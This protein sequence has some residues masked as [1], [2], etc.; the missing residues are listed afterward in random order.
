MQLHLA[1]LRALRGTAHGYRTQSRVDQKLQH[2]PAMSEKWAFP[3]PMTLT[4]TGPIMGSRL[5]YFCVRSAA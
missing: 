1:V 3:H 5:D 2:I 4:A